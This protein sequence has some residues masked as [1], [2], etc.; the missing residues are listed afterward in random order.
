M[1][2]LSPRE[3]ERLFGLLPDRSL[4]DRDGLEPARLAALKQ[5]ALIEPS[6]GRV[7]ERVRFEDGLERRS[8]EGPDD[9]RTHKH[10]GTLVRH[11]AHDSIQSCGR[12]LG[13]NSRSGVDKRGR[14]ARLEPT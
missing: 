2:E 5:G 3:A 12:L 1:T 8:L 14:L 9:D 4:W 13:R 10:S 11:V 7:R 6:L